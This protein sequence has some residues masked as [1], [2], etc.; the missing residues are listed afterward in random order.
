M[1]RKQPYRRRNYFIKKHFQTKFALRFAVLILVEAALIAALFFLIARGTA[2]TGYYGTQLRIEDTARFF[3]MTF[4]LIA[5]IA[6]AVVGVAAMI[7][8]I[9]YSHRIAGPLYRFQK[10]LS[11]LTLGDLTGRVH[12]RRRDQLGDLGETI[13]LLAV[14]TDRKIGQI[15]KDIEEALES[16][17]PARAKEA[18]MRARQTLNSFKTSP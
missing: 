18:I 8:F 9:Y 1:D 16:R 3:S 15:R 13:N 2:T 4:L 6:G 14:E 7:V 17:D 12:L 5:A 10:S 11:E